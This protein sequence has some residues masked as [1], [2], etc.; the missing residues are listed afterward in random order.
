MSLYAEYAQRRG[1]KTILSVGSSNYKHGVSPGNWSIL[2]ADG[3]ARRKLVEQIIT[4]TDELKFDALAIYWWYSGCPDNNCGK[5]D[6]KDKENLVSL[7][8]ELSNATKERNKSLFLIIPSSERTLSL[9]Y[10]MPE[11]SNYV[12]YFYVCTYNYEGTWNNYLGYSANLHYL[13]ISMDAIK[14]KL[15]AARMN[16]VIGGFTSTVTLY[17]LAIPKSRPKHKDP[18]YTASS[19]SYSTNILQACQAVHVENYTVLLDGENCNLAHNTT[20]VYVYEDVNTLRKKIEFFK[21]NGLG[22]L[23][24]SSILSDDEGSKCGCGFM[25]ILR[26]A[27]EILHGGDNSQVLILRVLSEKCHGP[28]LKDNI[29]KACI[30]QCLNLDSKKICSVNYTTGGF[31]EENCDTNRP[32]TKTLEVT[33]QKIMVCEV[34]P[35]NDAYLKGKKIAEYN[36]CTHF[37]F[38]S[39]H[40][41]NPVDKTFEP[42]TDNIPKQWPVKEYAQ[43]RGAKTILSFGHS[44]SQFGLSPG[45][46][47]I[48]S[49]S[50]D[51]R[52]KLI[53]QMILKTDEL[54]FDAVS[55]YWWYSACPDNNCAKGNSK[56]K[57][58][59]VS[60]MRE[61][62]QAIKARGKSLFLIL[63]ASKSVLNKGAHKN[64]HI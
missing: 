62:Y 7:M 10:N 32:F 23:F 12:D 42:R 20:H 47:S 52:A 37:H 14:G 18:V 4:Q 39:W 45:N 44:D 51:T 3:D 29:M 15:G 36:L 8:R 13:K 55:I 16:K 41:Y 25:P 26:I 2:A 27:A 54:K 53:E 22:G 28:E 34:H 1:V 57:E 6:K 63:P 24:Y 11:L 21:W 61:L 30:A 60:L 40:V 35:N 46:W 5:G 50:A 48:L 31:A 56:D 9:G 17:A 43:Q 64:S 38:G 58:N 33:D 19:L 49:A 59:L